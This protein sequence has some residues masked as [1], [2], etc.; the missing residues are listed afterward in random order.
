[1]R[2]LNQILP[3]LI[4]FV[5]WPALAQDN[6]YAGTWKLN[7][8]KSIGPA[9]ACAVL[10]NDGI[11][12]IAPGIFTGSPASNSAPLPARLATGSKSSQCVGAY[13]FTSSPD[14]R[15]LTITQPQINPEYKAVF[16]R[17]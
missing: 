12:R 5:A 14:G 17:Q 11:L 7:A 3:L 2:K 9:P 8:E 1:M 6:P 16:D 13:K 15:T 10:S 4:V